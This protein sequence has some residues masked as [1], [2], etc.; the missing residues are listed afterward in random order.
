MEGSLGILGF[1]SQE[2]V[3][4]SG[5]MAVHFVTGLPSYVMLLLQGLG[6]GI[7]ENLTASVA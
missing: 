7:A 4:D 6:T 2:F 1:A 5:S 3:I